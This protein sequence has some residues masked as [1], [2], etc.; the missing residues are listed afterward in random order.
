M[1]TRLSHCLGSLL[2]GVPIIG[3]PYL[4]N[5]LKKT[6]LCEV[7]WKQL[8]VLRLGWNRV[9]IISKQCTAILKVFDAGGINQRRIWVLIM[10]RYQTWNNGVCCCTTYLTLN[11]SVGCV[12]ERSSC[13]C[14]CTTWHEVVVCVCC[15]T[16]WHEVVV[17]LVLVQFLGNEQD[18]GRLPQDPT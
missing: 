13:V 15:Y 11:S 12:P 14:C 4:L 9:Q 8:C 5:T 3:G 17:H 16:T 10:L 1:T 2:F 18:L 6:L 7:W